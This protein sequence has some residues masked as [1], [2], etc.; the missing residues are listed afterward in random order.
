MSETKSI[1]PE[2]AGTIAKSV[3]ETYGP[4]PYLLQ[5]AVA[6]ALHSER[7]RCAK[8]AEQRGGELR[9]WA[10]GSDIA[11]TIRE[12]DAPPQMPA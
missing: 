4:D 11:N 8:A 6:A 9:E 1:I 10:I 2:W 7:E 12:P 5:G 3:V